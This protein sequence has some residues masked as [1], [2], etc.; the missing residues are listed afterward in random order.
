MSNFGQLSPAAMVELDNLNK[1]IEAITG[2]KTLTRSD[3]AKVDANLSKMASIRKAGITTDE[4]RRAKADHLGLV[5]TGEEI[6]AREAH[7]KLFRGFIAGKADEALD[8]EYRSNNDFLAGHAT[9]AFSAGPQGGVLVPM[10]F[11]QS[12]TL[13]LARN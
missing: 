3:R 11:Q 10:R 5:I 2:K 12:V 6:R 13:G 8:Y 7:E 1:E 4:Y 9:P